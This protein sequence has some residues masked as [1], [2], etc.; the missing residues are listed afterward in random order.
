MYL[1]ML[2]Q[3]SVL[4][5]YVTMVVKYEVGSMRNE[6]AAVFATIL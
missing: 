6:D 5:L 3:Y 2:H 1:A 4:A